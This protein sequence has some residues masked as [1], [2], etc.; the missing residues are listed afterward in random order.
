MF[1]VSRLVDYEKTT[2]SQAWRH[3][4]SDEPQMAPRSDTGPAVSPDPGGGSGWEGM[5]SKGMGRY[6]SGCGGKLGDLMSWGF[7]Q[8]CYAV[9]VGIGW[10]WLG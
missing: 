9:M 5:V 8:S 6:G 1:L 7:L 2:A 10:G 3:K 4:E